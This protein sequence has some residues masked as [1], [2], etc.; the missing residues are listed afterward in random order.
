MVTTRLIESR[1]AEALA[2]LLVVNRDFLAPYEPLREQ[3]YFTPAGQRADI[4]AALD[5]HERGAGLPRVVLDEGG[6]L[7]GRITLSGIV[8]GALLSCSI[9]YWIA[10]AAGGRGA[11]TAAVAQMTEIAFGQLGLHRVQAETLV[12]NVRSQRVL[13]K[14]GFT[15]YGLAP[16][17]L[18]IAGRWQDHVMHQLLSPLR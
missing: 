14:N 16:Q 12:D 13:Q 8:R 7:I 6:Q 3:S 17:Y 4:H 5:A 9:G 2:H 15:R 10:Q 1:D 18:K 11:A